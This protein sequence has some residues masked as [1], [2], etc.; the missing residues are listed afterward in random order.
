MDVI[1]G[2]NG[3]GWV[4]TRTNS[5]NTLLEVT[6][7]SATSSPQVVSWVPLEF[8]AGALG[9]VSV[10]FTS[11]F[12]RFVEIVKASRKLLHSPAC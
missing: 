12:G 9:Y 11:L 6:D 8:S 7:S 5:T 1:D 4:M 10:G 2:W 3:M